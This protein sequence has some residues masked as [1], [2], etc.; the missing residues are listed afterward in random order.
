MDREGNR[1]KGE[2]KKTSEAGGLDG[3]MKGGQRERMEG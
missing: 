2:E 3:V 1:K